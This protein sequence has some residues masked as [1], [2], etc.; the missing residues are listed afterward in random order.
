MVVPGSHKREVP[1]LPEGVDFRTDSGNVRYEDLRTDEQRGL[2]TELTGKAGTAVI[3][4]HDIIH[5]SARPQCS[6]LLYEV[7]RSHR[8]KVHRNHGNGVPWHPFP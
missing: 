3:F 1:Y 4:T 2:F 7:H 6:D 5:Q 8:W